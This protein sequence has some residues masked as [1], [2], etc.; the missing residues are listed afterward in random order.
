MKLIRFDER[1]R[2][3]G[4]HNYPET[5]S[6]KEK[7]GGILTDVI[8]PEVEQRFGKRGILKYDPETNSVYVEY[9]DRPLTTEEQMQE[10]KDSVDYMVLQNE[11][12]V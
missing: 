8:I 10:L 11:G 7:E 2:I 1:N 6:D 9:V 12:L 4:Y 5:L 3:T